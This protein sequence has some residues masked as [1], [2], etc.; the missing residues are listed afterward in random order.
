MSQHNQ[1][2]RKNH[3]KKLV[4][5]SKTIMTH[6]ITI[7]LGSQKMAK[8]LY[9]INNIEPLNEI[10]L[11]VFSKYNTKIQHLPSG[12]ERLSYNK[13]L[14]LS[15]DLQLDFITANYKNEIIEK[16]FGIVQRYD[17]NKV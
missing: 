9:W 10:D 1:E 7:P 4:S 11:S 8:I 14:L 17:I 2:K 16:C 3:I 5:N 15:D 6:Q 13:D 12:V